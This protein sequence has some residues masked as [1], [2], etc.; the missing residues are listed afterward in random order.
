MNNSCEKAK[1]EML[2]TLKLSAWPDHTSW[3]QSELSRRKT[4]IAVGTAAMK[5]NEGKKSH[6]K[7]TNY[8]IMFK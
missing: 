1:N 7:R 3:K 4:S 5:K 2:A 8:L 6:Y